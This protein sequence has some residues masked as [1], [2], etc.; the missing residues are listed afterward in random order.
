MA[1]TPIP[2]EKA[3]RDLGIYLEAWRK[4]QRLS[5]GTLSERA[6]LSKITLRKLEAGSGGTS[7]ENVL[8]VMHVLGVMDSVV[9]S[10]DPYTTDIGKLRAEETLPQ[11]IRGN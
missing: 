6:G 3:L 1:A 2:V 8:R 11:R 9:K 4:L 7:I 10:V 5:I